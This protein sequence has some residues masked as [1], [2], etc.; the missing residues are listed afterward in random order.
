MDK[1]TGI[2]IRL[3]MSNL[4]NVTH[5]FQ[6]AY[7]QWDKF[8]T[9]KDLSKYIAVKYGRSSKKSRNVSNHQLDLYLEE[10][11]VLPPSEDIRLL[12][13]G[14]LVIVKPKHKS[15]VSV[16]INSRDQTTKERNNEN[17]STFGNNV[18]SNSKLNGS[19]SGSKVNLTVNKR[20]SKETSKMANEVSETQNGIYTQNSSYVSSSSTSSSSDS[21]STTNYNR[22]IIIN[23]KRITY[24]CGRCTKKS[25]TLRHRLA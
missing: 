9:V 21:D 18:S 17:K 16:D 20:V 2:R 8:S 23:R 1:P 14:D 10:P 13:N 4:L 22:K 6:W 19:S 15:L 24:F 12:Q 3:D 25:K 7:I 5:K 11:F